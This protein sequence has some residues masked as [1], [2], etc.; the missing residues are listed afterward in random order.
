MHSKVKFQK[1]FDEVN[2]FNHLFYVGYLVIWYDFLETILR[3]RKQY[4]S[5]L[6]YLLEIPEI[7]MMFKREQQPNELTVRRF[8]IIASAR[9]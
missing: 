1:Y 2:N 4:L 6:S 9:R 7:L 3:S 8:Q 5:L